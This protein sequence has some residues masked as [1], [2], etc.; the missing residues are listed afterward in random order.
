VLVTGET[1]ISEREQIK[2][3]LETG[4]KSCIAGSRQIFSEGISINALSCVILS[5][6]IANEALLEQIIGRI[7]RIHPN[8][9]SPVVV[10]I[11]FSG[12][13]DKRQNALRLGFY[14]SKGWQIQ[15]I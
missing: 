6:P 5:S 12:H 1:G 2:Q 13:T 15:T 8:K 3:Q 4:E 7:M 9:L 10:D 11:Q 14:A